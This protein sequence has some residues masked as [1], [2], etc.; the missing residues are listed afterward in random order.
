LPRRRA[1][2]DADWA[3]ALAERLSFSRCATHAPLAVWPLGLC[4]AALS[5]AAHDRGNLHARS[6]E[7]RTARNW[8]WTWVRARG[9][10]L[11]RRKSR[12]GAGGLCRGFGPHPAR[13]DAVLTHVSR[14]ILQLRQGAYGTAAIPTAASAGLVRRA[15][16]RQ[17]CARGP[18]V[19][20]GR[21]PRPGEGDLCVVRKLPQ[22]LARGEG[23][24]ATAADGAGAVCRGS[25][26]RSSRARIGAPRLSALAPELHASPSLAW[27]SDGASA[28]A[29][30]RW[31]GRSGPGHCGI[32]VDGG[33]VSAPGTRS[34]RRQLLRRSICI[35]RFVAV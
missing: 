35:R 17:C 1:S 2:F 15:R 16:T 22:G 6:H 14:P 23:L 19:P 29:R 8:L 27:A 32:A 33:G 13:A 10:C 11:L 31:P 12:G 5:S 26:D 3:R 28:S 34:D 25:R 24:S 18:Q 20:A 4:A 30:F 21:E 7:P 9:T